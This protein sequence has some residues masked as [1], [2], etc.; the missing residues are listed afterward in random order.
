MN[1]FNRRKFLQ[2]SG[3]A[4]IPVTVPAHAF[5]DKTAD[6]EMQF[7]NPQTVSFVS[8]GP[9]YNPAQYIDKLKEIT[10]G[11]EVARD[12]YGQG[13]VVEQLCRK[14]ASITGKSAAVFIPTGTLANQLALATLSGENSKVFVQE[15]SHVYRD[16]AD[17]AQTLFNKRL[18]PLA[19]GQPFFTAEELEA[20]VN[21]HQQEE[22][23]KTGIGA[24]SIEVPVRRNDNRTFPID[25]IKKISAYCRKNNFKMHLDG[26]RIHLD[27]AFTGVSVGEYAKYFDSVYMCTYKYLGANG[28]AVLC[29]DESLIS[30]MDHLIKI[31]GG[32]IFSNWPNAAIALHNLEGIEQRL[33]SVAAKAKEWINTMKQIPGLKLTALD[34]GTN[35]Y[36]LAFAKNM[37]IDKFKTTLRTKYS[38][39]TGVADKEGIIRIRFNETFLNQDNVTLTKA[40]AEAIAAAK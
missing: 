23:F 20:S 6:E 29:G 36:Y 31:H 17:A 35:V 11:K 9:L 32:S 24:V 22:V 28:G 18:I 21:Y 33:S 34:G 25:E 1:S 40:F 16:E 5:A 8:E 10:T 15:T 7:A 38:I 4:A 37:D 14:M 39:F 19:K 30:K 27:A 26:A 3:L 12:F 2:L 13:G